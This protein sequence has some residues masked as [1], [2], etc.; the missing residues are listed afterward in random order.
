MAV[1]VSPVIRS[2]LAAAGPVEAERHQ[3]GP[4]HPTLS[5][6]CRLQAARDG[7]YGSTNTVTLARPISLRLVCTS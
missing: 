5:P 7:R 6:E 4:L 3:P 1:E 2:P